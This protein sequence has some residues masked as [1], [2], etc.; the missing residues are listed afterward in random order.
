MP[1]RDERTPHVEQP[2]S[3]ARG[4]RHSAGRGAL[5]E[6][7]EQ[8]EPRIELIRDQSLYP[9]MRHAA[10]FTGDPAFS[11]DA[12]A[13][14]GVRGHARLRRRALRHSRRR[15][16]RPEADGGREP[17][18]A[19]GAHHGGRGRRCGQ[20]R[21][22]RRR[23]AA[24]GSSSPPRP[25]CT[26]GRSPSSRSSACWPGPR[27]CR[28]CSR[29]SATTPGADDGRCARSS[30]MTVLV[31]GLGGIGSEVARRLAGLGRD[32]GRHQP[33]PAARR[34][35]R[36]VD[37]H[38][39]DRR[40]RARRGRHRA[41]PAGDGGHRAAHRRGCAGGGEARHDP[42][43]RR[44]R[45]RGRR[46]RTVAGTARRPDRLRGAGRVRHRAAAG[47][48]ARCGTSRTCWSARTRRR[49][50]QQRTD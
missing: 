26:A 9:P 35:R 44:P 33:A 43:Q 29:S 50:T 5:C 21:R 19:L 3:A 4:R 34:P 48:T 28:G 38:R 23:T 32:R 15:P 31:V 45:N 30:E 16:G 42:G 37:P 39:P 25:G 24:A 49:S 47:A 18:A 13:A 2:W 46:G 12:R 36:P 22:A 7:I 27:T 40:D 10:D 8:L 20:G 41:D 11:A 17:G 14:A 1:L 6:L